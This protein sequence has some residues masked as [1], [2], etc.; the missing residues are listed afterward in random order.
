MTTAGMFREGLTAIVRG[1]LSTG[2]PLWKAVRIVNFS[3]L[4]VLA[5]L[6][7]SVLGIYAIDVGQSPEP[8]GEISAVAARQAVFLV[9]GLIACVTVALPHYRYIGLF[10]WPLY[11]AGIVLLI[12][13]IMPGIPSWLVHPRNGSRRWINMGMMDLQPVEIAKIAFVLA[14]A[15]YMRFRSQHRRLKGLVVPG[16]IAAVPIGLITLQPDLGSAMLFVPALFAM[17]IAAGAR[18]RHLTLIV[19]CA[20]LAA[21]AAWPVLKPYQKTR[22]I[23]LY[24]QFQGDTT[25]AFDINYQALTAQTLIG[26]GQAQG[27][28]ESGSR[29]LVHYNRLPERHNDMISAVI[30]NRF[31]FWGGLGLM[32][33]Y[34]IWMGG[35]WMVAASCRDPLGRLIAAGLPVFIGVQALINIGMNLGLM[36]IIGVTLPFVSYGGSSLLSCWIMTGLIV[37]VAMHK[38]RPPFRA[39]FEYADDNGPD[40]MQAT[41]PYG[42]SVGFSGRALTR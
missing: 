14:V 6:A 5:A 4:T 33:L 11:A 16:I 23:G 20:A 1:S 35:A 31:G 29:A 9:I 2:E 13:L 10:S 38:P 34:L 40:P 18:L 21:P 28:G 12:V 41:K 3:W 15:R 7:L 32:G 27:R 25:T 19:A 37:N 39:S 8:T 42:R 24:K 22:L 26:A 30:V 36:P 17:L